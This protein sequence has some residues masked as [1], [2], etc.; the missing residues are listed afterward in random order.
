MTAKSG[1]RRYVV[2]WNITLISS[3]ESS[4]TKSFARN[5]RTLKKARW[6][7]Y[8]RVCIHIYICDINTYIYMCVVV[9]CEGANRQ[10]EKNAKQNCRSVSTFS[11]PRLRLPVAHWLTRNRGSPL[12]QTR[13]LTTPDSHSN[14]ERRTRSRSCTPHT[15]LSGRQSQL[16]SAL[17]V[18]RLR[19]FSVSTPPRS[20]SAASRTRRHPH[21]VA[22]RRS[23]CA[24]A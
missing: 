11:A 1:Y 4:R 14:S 12:V 24:D 21:T 18:V 13:S 8:E 22:N 9:S 3:I 17:S 7:H 16:R 15:V 20:E 6:L 10:K 2:A 23:R 19:F 5:N